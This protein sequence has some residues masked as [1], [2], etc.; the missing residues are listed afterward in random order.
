MGLQTSSRSTREGVLS[1]YTDRGGHSFYV[2]GIKE[3][4]H[5]ENI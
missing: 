5:F 1:S 4:K 3:L 2:S